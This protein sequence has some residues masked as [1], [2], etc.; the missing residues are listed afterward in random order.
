MILVT[1]AAGKTG[2]AII[3]AL[4]RRGGDVRALAYRRRQAATLEELG[5]REVVVGDVQDPET[6]TA[7]ARGARAIYHI[8][9]NMHPREVEIGKMV[10]AAARSAGCERFVYHSVLHP[11]TETMPHHWHKLRVEE[12]LFESGLPCTILQPAAYMQ[13]VLA[14]WQAITRDGVYAV[15][16]AAETRI[17]MVD[18]DDVAEA[19]AR[20]LT[21]PGHD[22]AT[23]ELSGP[24]FLSQEQVSAVLAEGLGRRVRVDVVPIDVWTA[25]ARDAGLGDFQVET[26]SRMFRYY[27]RYGFRGN[28]RVLGWLLDRPPADFRAFVERVTNDSDLRYP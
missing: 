18:L 6:L 16:Y 26:L 11:Q 17:S 2:Q 19:A 9:P 10:V 12:M 23:Y 8:C 14:G 7:A 28:P 25:K 22:G 5:A 13:N 15:P 21:E 20:V 24:G 1:G 4:A 3:R 27:Q